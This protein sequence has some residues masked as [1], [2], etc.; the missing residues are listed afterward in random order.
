[1]S[2]LFLLD[3]YGRNLHYIGRYLSGLQGCFSEKVILHLRD[4]RDVE[5][6]AKLFRYIVVV[7]VGTMES[8]QPKEGG[9][10]HNVKNKITQMLQKCLCESNIVS[11]YHI[12]SYYVPRRLPV[13]RYVRY[14]DTTLHI[15]VD[16]CNPWENSLTLSGEASLYSC[17]PVCL[18]WTTLTLA[19]DL[20]VWIN[21][22]QS[23][24][25]AVQGF[26]HLRITYLQCIIR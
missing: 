11:L 22:I 19:T 5:I 20:L 21:P 13:S 8:L 14:C 24:R 2:I 18:L 1:M 7:V 15:I 10:S 9:R 3:V 16:T 4:V 26:F 6:G 12:I 17:P 25:S 23:N